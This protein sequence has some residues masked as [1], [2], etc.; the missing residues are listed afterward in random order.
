MPIFW[1]D[2]TQSLIITLTSPEQLMFVRVGWWINQVRLARLYRSR[3]VQPFINGSKRCTAAQVERLVPSQ[4]MGV[5]CISP[6]W[7]FSV[8]A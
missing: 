3:F 2:D 1:I 4:P 8:S 7:A 5:D 6:A